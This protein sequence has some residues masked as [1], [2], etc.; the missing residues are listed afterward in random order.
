M[1]RSTCSVWRRFYDTF[2]TEGTESGSGRSVDIRVGFSNIIKCISTVS[3]SVPNMFK[4]D[5]QT[6]KKRIITNVDSS[7]AILP[8]SEQKIIREVISEAQSEISSLDDEILARV[9][10]IY[11]GIAPHK[12]LPPELLTLIFSHV[13]TDKYVEAPQGPLSLLCALGQVCSRW[14]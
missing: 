6:L 14:K 7:N 11:A 1:S 4:F 12:M 9:N 8:D 13:M 3:P 2:R 10:R 5:P